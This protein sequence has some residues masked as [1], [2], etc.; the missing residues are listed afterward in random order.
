MRFSEEI[1]SL[2][3]ILYQDQTRVAASRAESDMVNISL[4]III[5]VKTG[6]RNV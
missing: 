2:A 6:R 5:M 4:S 3:K 1:E